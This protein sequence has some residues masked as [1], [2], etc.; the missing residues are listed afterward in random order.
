MQAREFRVWNSVF[1]VEWFRVECGG[2][3]SY[4]VTPGRDLLLSLSDK[5]VGP[6]PALLESHELGVGRLYLGLG[7]RDQGFGVRRRVMATLSTKRSFPAVFPRVA[8]SAVTSRMSSMICSGWDS[9]FRV[10][11]FEIGNR[12]SRRE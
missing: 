1:R 7:S 9:G 11:S 2:L 5:L 8:E 4:L 12:P 6:L 3:E 10:Q